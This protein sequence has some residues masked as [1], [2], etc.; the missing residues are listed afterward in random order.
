M[1]M[2]LNITQKHID[3][4]IRK[5]CTNCPVAVL[6]KEM[7]HKY[8]GVSYGWLQFGKFK[9]NIAHTELSEFIMS[10]DKGEN[11][12]PLETEITIL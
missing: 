11:V 3:S 2:I 12:K 9:A 4:G 10:Y 8:V 5:D 1:K 6:L 7:G